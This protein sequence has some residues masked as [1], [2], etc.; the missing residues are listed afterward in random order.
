MAGGERS[1]WKGGPWLSRRARSWELQQVGGSGPADQSPEFSEGT[2]LPVS[3]PDKETGGGRQRQPRGGRT[4]GQDGGE[5]RAASGHRCCGKE[6][7]S[8]LKPRLF[9][10]AGESRPGGQTG[11]RV[12]ASS[13]PGTKAK[14]G[15]TAGK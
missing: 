4:G 10:P 9:C 11:P 15:G 12:G 13:S 14:A 2:E 5:S 3:V 7:D 8:G 1:A 6:Q